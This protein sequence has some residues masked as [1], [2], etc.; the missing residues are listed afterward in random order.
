M[1]RWLNGLRRAIRHHIHGRPATASGA[2]REEEVE[3]GIHHDDVNNRTNDQQQEHQRY[4]GSEGNENKGPNHDWWNCGA[5][6]NFWSLFRQNNT[7]EALGWGAAVVLGIQL[8]KHPKWVCHKNEEYR[9]QH[10]LLYRVAHA[11]PIHTGK[12]VIDGDRKLHVDGVIGEEQILDGINDSSETKSE[13]K[14]NHE[15]P[16][17]KV[18]SEFEAMCKRYTGIARNIEG[19]DQAK[20]GHMTKAAERWSVGSQLGYSK[21]NFNLGLCYETGQGVKKDLS[22]AAEH[23][24]MAGEDGHP[25]ALYNLALM[26]LEGRGVPKDPREAIHLLEKA[27]EYGLRQAQ[28]YLGVHYTTAETKDMERAVNL[29]Q[30]AARQDD[31]EAQYFLG[32]CYE[33]GL[34]VAVNEC[35]AADLYSQSASGGHDG[36]MYNLAVFHEYGLGGLPEDRLTAEEL[37]RKS[38][39]LGNEHAQDRLDQSDAIEAVSQWEAQHYHRRLDLDFVDIDDQ[40]LLTKPNTQEVGEKSKLSSSASTPSLTDYIRKH[41]ADLQIGTNPLTVLFATNNNP[42][43]L[44]H[45]HGPE[46][47]HVNSKDIDIQLEDSTS[48]PALWEPQYGSPKLSSSPPPQDAARVA[49]SLGADEDDIESLQNFHDDLDLV[50]GNLDDLHLN[51]HSLNHKTSTMPNLQIV[52]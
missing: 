23:Y 51:I 5:Q 26:Y 49:F 21:S 43:L 6:F 47:T 8:S 2:V 1:W 25:Q 20:R 46:L 31:S 9:G 15:D 12:V 32:I 4:N 11:L 13:N 40:T 22:K 19:N 52:Y 34:G 17:G 7:L 18:F 36:A 50:V 45:Q 28:T 42:F 24:Q 41:L 44:Q 29:F 39:S 27:A 38:A 16:V 35:K 3:H 10:C 37:Y 48:C 30:M 14:D 33:Q